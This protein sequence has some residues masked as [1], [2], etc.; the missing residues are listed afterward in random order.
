[1]VEGLG[2]SEEV[3]RMRSAGAVL[4]VPEEARP[5]DPPHHHMVQGVRRFQAAHDF[6]KASIMRAKSFSS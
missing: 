2:V 6:E 3:V 5:L 4:V 1:M